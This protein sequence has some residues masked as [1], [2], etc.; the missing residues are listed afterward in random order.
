VTSV[1]TRACVIRRG[2]ETI[3]QHPLAS[4]QAIAHYDRYE[5]CI[6]RDAE[7]VAGSKDAASTS[8][9]VHESETTQ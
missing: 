7:R 1:S 4:E 6:T 2:Q 8:E 5:P 9:A 3:S